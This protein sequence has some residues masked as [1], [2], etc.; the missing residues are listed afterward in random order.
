[1]DFMK[2]PPAGA[3][4][5]EIAAYYTLLR[6]AERPRPVSSLEQPARLWRVEEEVL[7]A[8]EIC[9]KPV[10]RK[11]G[12]TREQ[13]RELRRLARFLAAKMAEEFVVTQRELGELT[14]LSRAVCKA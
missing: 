14:K 8:L 12:T 1:M 6:Q 3:N 4:A 7:T 13:I 2:P 5:A 9:R 10:L 11:E